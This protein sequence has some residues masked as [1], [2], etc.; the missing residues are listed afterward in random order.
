M[1]RYNQRAT[2]IDSRGDDFSDLLYRLVVFDGVRSYGGGLATGGVQ[3]CGVVACV[4]DSVSSCGLRAD[5]QG[6]HTRPYQ[7][8]TVFNDIVITPRFNYNSTFVYPDVLMTGVGDQFGRLMPSDQFDYQQFGP[9]GDVL[10]S[11]LRIGTP[12]QGLVS[13]AV[14][15]R[16]FDRD[17]LPR[18]ELSQASH[19][20]GVPACIVVVGLTAM[21]NIYYI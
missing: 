12:V 9:Y 13:A 1:T 2:T 15:A 17:G 8:L 10:L 14:Y 7:T 19:S 11:S 3:V 16:Q 21:L 18:T 6:R 4:N 20:H 5:S